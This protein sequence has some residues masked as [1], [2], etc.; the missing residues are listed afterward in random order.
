VEGKVFEGKRKKQ[1]LFFKV[2]LHG[3]PEKAGEL[4][5]KTPLNIKQW[6]IY[7]QSITYFVVFLLHFQACP[8]KYR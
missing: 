6:Q 7:V 4:T 2:F 8:L 5:S 3:F 1:V